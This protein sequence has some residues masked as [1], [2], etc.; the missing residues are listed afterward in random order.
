MLNGKTANTYFIVF[1]LINGAQTHD[2]LHSR[3]AHYSLMSSDTIRSQNRYLGTDLQIKTSFIFHSL[4]CITITRKDKFT[5]RQI[6]KP[7]KKCK[8]LRI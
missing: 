8:M 4:F 3:Q 6:K 5:I 7:I 2:L 1:C